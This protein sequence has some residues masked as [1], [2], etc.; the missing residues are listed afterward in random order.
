MQYQSSEELQVPVSSFCSSACVS[1]YD[2]VTQSIKLT[3]QNDR[4]ARPVKYVPQRDSCMHVLLKI[5]ETMDCLRL[6]CTGISGYQ[7]LLTCL[8]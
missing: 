5:K 7:D 6:E 4:R 1:E 3:M 8:F 2:A